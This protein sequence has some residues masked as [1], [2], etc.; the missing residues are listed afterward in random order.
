M[1]CFW[2]VDDEKWQYEAML[3]R[4]VVMKLVESEGAAVYLAAHTGKQKEE[5]LGWQGKQWGII[6]RR[7]FVRRVPV[8]YEL[9]GQQV[10]KF[11]RAMEALLTLRRERRIIEKNVWQRRNGLPDIEHVPVRLPR[12]VNWQRCGDQETTERLLRWAKKQEV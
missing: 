3:L 9:Q 5:Q 7:L 2:C 12:S 1:D 11:H 10:V 4:S 6:N 8:E